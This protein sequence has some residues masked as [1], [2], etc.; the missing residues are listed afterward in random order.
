M[1]NRKDEYFDNEEIIRYLREPK[2]EHQILFLHLLELIKNDPSKDILY[3]IIGNY[4]EKLSEE[5]MEAWLDL[6]I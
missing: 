5:E 2:K 6:N 4:I 3:S 1:E